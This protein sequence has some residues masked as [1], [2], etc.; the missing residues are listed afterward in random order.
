MSMRDRAVRRWRV[1]QQRRASL[2][3]IHGNSSFRTSLLAWAGFFG[4]D[5]LDSCAGAVA[6]DEDLVGDA[7][8]VR[9]VDGVD[10]VQLAEELSPVAV[11]GLVF[12]QLMG[13]AFVVGE[14][15]QQVGAGAGLEACELFV[16]D[17]FG[18]QAVELFVD[19]GRASRRACG[20]GGERRRRRRGR[21]TC[22]RGSR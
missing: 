12:G 15:A 20:R 22:R 7:A 19:G 6:V 1:L 18:L 13:E 10:L 21:G 3:S 8:D 2:I 4:C 5:E 14:A 16:G 11:A 17:V 9:F